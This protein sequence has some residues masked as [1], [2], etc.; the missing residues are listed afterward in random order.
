MDKTNDFFPYFSTF[1]GFIFLGQ[2]TNY[3]CI[4]EKNLYRTTISM[5]EKKKQA[6]RILISEK[7][8]D[9]FF[10]PI[11]LCYAKQEE[12]EKTHGHH[13]NFLWFCG[14][15]HQYSGFLFCPPPKLSW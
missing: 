3:I 1:F 8:I 2:I 15:S 5:F 4:M 11:N 6:K 13:N 9:H 10:Q 7:K 14:L 12:E